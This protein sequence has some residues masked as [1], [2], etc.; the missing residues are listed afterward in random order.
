E[1]LHYLIAALRMLVDF[2]ITI[3]LC[4]AV[5][6]YTPNKYLGF[7]LSLVPLLF[8]NIVF[9]LLEWNNQIYLFGSGGPHMPYSDMNGYGHTVGTWL[10][11][12]GYWLAIVLVLCML[13]LFVFAR[14]KEKSWKAKY[15]LSKPEFSRPYVAVLFACMLIALSAGGYI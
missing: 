2:S 15:R 1:P 13:A 11:Y 12:N 14:G 6:V 5:Q 4:L 8:V 7:F 9:S 3:G 10:L